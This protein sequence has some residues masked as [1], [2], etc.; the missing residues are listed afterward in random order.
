MSSD[1]VNPDD[2][3][4]SSEGIFENMLETSGRPQSASK[5]NPFVL[6]VQTGRHQGKIFELR[7]ECLGVAKQFFVLQ[8]MY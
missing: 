2:K 3:A 6:A 4:P 1:P 8:Q 5:E 7:S